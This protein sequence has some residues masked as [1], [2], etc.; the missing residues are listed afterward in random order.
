METTLTALGG[1]PETIPP[2]KPKRNMNP[3]SLEALRLGREK[4]LAQRAELKIGEKKK[5]QKAL[6]TVE[7]E[8]KYK[9]RLEILT[10]ERAALRKE[11]DE[12]VDAYILPKD[13]PV[14]QSKRVPK[15]ESD[16]EDC[17]EAIDWKTYYKSKYK[18]KMDAQREPEYATLARDKLRQQANAHAKQLAWQ[19]IFPGV[20][21]N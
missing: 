12:K 17:Q 14:R 18:A 2:A 3:N 8:Q 19:S 10:A 6:K 9:K 11:V 16:S 13:A 4:V 20:P 1:T 5:L 15:A 7:N 21:Y